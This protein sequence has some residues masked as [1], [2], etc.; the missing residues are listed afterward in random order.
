[1]ADRWRKGLIGG[2]YKQIPF[3]A[4]LP[5][6]ATTAD[7]IKI[8]TA[9]TVTSATVGLECAGRKVVLLAGAAVTLTSGATLSLAGNFTMLAG[10]TI[11]LVSDGVTWHEVT[12]SAGA[13]AGSV[14]TVAAAA[15][16]P[17]LATEATTFI[18]TGATAITSITTSASIAG[19]VITLIF[20]SNPVVTA[21][22]NLKLAAGANFSSSADDTMQLVTDGTNWYEVGRSA[23]A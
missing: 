14:A 22:S 9:G 2:I 21:G 20:Q 17:A 8:M 18:V 1:M 12:R 10:D 23:N 7:L 16:F 5:L 6:R 19:R 15:A 11:T 13:A 4:V 3:T